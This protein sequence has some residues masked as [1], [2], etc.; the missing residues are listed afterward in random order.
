MNNVIILTISLY[1][2]ISL[3]QSDELGLEPLSQWGG[4]TYFISSKM[5]AA[6]S[7][8][9]ICSVYGYKLLSIEDDNENQFVKEQLQQLHQKDRS[10]GDVWTSGVAQA[11]STFTR[12]FWLSGGGSFDPD[13]DYSS[14]QMEFMDFSK[15][16]HVGIRNKKR[17]KENSVIRNRRNA[18]YSNW[19][20]YNT[21][22]N[23]QKQQAYN[24]QQQ[25]LYDD[26]QNQYQQLT[27]ARYVT[28]EQAQYYQN[29]YQDSNYNYQYSNQY[30]EAQAP[31]PVQVSAQNEYQYQNQ[32]QNQY[33]AQVGT[34]QYGYSSN[35]N[36]AIEIQRPGSSNRCN[37]SC[38]YSPYCDRTPKC[39]VDLQPC[40][41]RKRE[42]SYDTPTCSATRG[43][44]S[45]ACPPCTIDPPKC[46]VTQG[47][48]NVTTAPC[49]LR[50]QPICTLRA[51]ECT[52][53]RPPCTTRP[54]NCSVKKSKVP[55]PTT[56]KCRP[57]GC[58][59]VQP[60]CTKEQGP[61]TLTTGPCPA[62]SGQM[63]QTQKCPEPITKCPPPYTT[64][65]PFIDCTPII[66]QSPLI[67][68][69]EPTTHCPNPVTY[70]PPATIVCG[71]P[72]I[73]CPEPDIVCPEPVVKC[74][75]PIAVCPKGVSCPGVITHCTDAKVRCNT[76]EV[77][78]P[79]PK[80]ECQ[81]PPTCTPPE[82]PPYPDPVCPPGYEDCCDQKQ[83]YYQQGDQAPQGDQPVRQEDEPSGY[84]EDVPTSDVI[85]N[86]TLSDNQDNDPKEVDVIHQVAD[87]DVS[88][89]HFRCIGLA[90]K[91]A[92]KWDLKH[93][94][95]KRRFI[96]EE[97][98]SD[99]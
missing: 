53:T 33:Q 95:D 96:C 66:C 46:T 1:F 50:K 85:A 42:C 51:E 88:R 98:T 4:K 78:C 44:C 27:T 3:G 68:C 24:N 19:R 43:N 16:V 62:N 71:E 40:V 80:I 82:V 28:Q 31:A 81:P 23:Q 29:P 93:C 55:C 12:T 5:V 75:K 34:N 72:D 74:S 59:S 52:T 2:Q 49:T 54:G 39:T 30:Y 37:C 67:V 14:A 60:P 25:T 13:S 94:T 73:F 10:V 36:Q 70:C 61:C 32:Y 89:N 87:E 58:E 97:G 92:F 63:C 77:S 8:A 45:A 11:N 83:S 64:C 26:W 99:E 84:Q 9:E 91:H 69:Q 48:C 79:P 41:T 38:D 17:Q 57:G 18:I 20:S 86:S 76:P 90:E 6:N 15:I 7:A 65:R 56:P 22:T 35:V 21:N 47:A